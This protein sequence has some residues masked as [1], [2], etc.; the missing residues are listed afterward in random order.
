M[1]NSLR[2]ASVFGRSASF[3]YAVLIILPSA[4][5]T[6][7]FVYD[8]STAAA[9]ASG[10]PVDTD[11][12][13][14]DT[15]DNWVSVTATTGNGNDDVV[16]NS[17]HP[18][19]NFS[20]NYYQSFDL[21]EPGNGDSIY[22]RLNDANF[23]YS[24][25]SGASSVSFSMISRISLNPGFPSA[26][27]SAGPLGDTVSGALLAGNFGSGWGIRYINPVSNVISANG[28][29]AAKLDGTERTY[30][31]TMSVDMTPVGTT[32]LVD[33]LVENLTDGGSELIFDDVALDLGVMADPSVWDGLQIRFNG[34]STHGA[35][36]D[37]LQISWVPEPASS[38]LVL[39]SFCWF[40]RR[41]SRH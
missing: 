23:S 5:A 3:V 11:A 26:G 39:F 13:P 22:R 31:V 33:L 4:Q 25:P 38:T 24:I 20:G 28:T 36:L 35:Y 34:T 7:V 15:N 41:R 16:R 1:I 2:Y 10:V 18:D 21:S 6:S 17:G 12:L 8:W 29:G 19:G 32:K 30:R 14:A 9:S 40:L 27:G 37:D